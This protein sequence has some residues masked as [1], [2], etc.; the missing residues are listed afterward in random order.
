MMKKVYTLLFLALAFFTFSCDNDD[1]TP[2]DADLTLNLE[3]LEALGA[4]FVYEGWLIVDGLPV[5]TGTFTSVSFPQSFT[6]DY[7]DLMSAT[8]FV[9]SI[10]P[11]VDSDPGPASTKIL[12]GD[13]SGNSATVNTGIVGDF[14]SSTGS[15]ILATPTDGEMSNENSG[16]WF[17][18]PT[19]GT[20][21]AGLDLPTLSAGWKY[22]GWAVIGG[23]PVSTGTFTN[24]AATDDFDGFSGPMPLPAPNGADGFFP[25][26][27]F[28]INAPA[29][30]I[31]PTDLESGTA[32][33]SVEPFPDDSPT[34]FT[35]K[36]LVGA[37]PAGAMDHTLYTM[38]QNLGSL[39]KGS[40]SR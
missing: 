36:P 38:G 7:D 31:F 20:P 2:A 16:I 18:D 30:L 25:G 19:S 37:I 21:M 29:G 9:L 3:G 23:M 10:E 1:D 17:L 8:K 12:V 27:D 40:V 24:V 28:L 6:V 13:F 39:P 33:I 11:A 15:Y 22:E 26:E 14:M 5:S 4:N 34:P 35:L 32:V